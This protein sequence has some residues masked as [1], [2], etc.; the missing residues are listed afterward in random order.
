M[1]I[2][3]KDEDNKSYSALGLQSFIM[4]AVLCGKI[5]QKLRSKVLIPLSGWNGK[6]SE[7]NNEKQPASD[8]VIIAIRQ[9][10]RSTEFFPVH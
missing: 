6:S 7:H 5:L 10:P 8:G 1:H 4:N 9:R 3:K 2:V